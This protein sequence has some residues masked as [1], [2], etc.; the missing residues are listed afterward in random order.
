MA[1]PDQRLLLSEPVLLRVDNGG[2]APMA[3]YR[4]PPPRDGRRAATPSL[5]GTNSKSITVES[6]NIGNT[7]SQNRCRERQDAVVD[8]VVELDEAVL[9]DP[10]AKP[11][12]IGGA[13]ACGG[14]VG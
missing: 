8:G 5:S 7:N 14:S 3:T 4:W 1:H 10:Q 12:Q 9:L 6:A 11:I 2:A 13:A